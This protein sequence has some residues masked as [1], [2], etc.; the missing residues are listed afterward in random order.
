MVTLHHNSNTEMDSRINLVLQN[1]L[2]KIY[3]TV[4]VYTA[5][6]HIHFHSYICHFRTHYQNKS[7]VKTTQ[8]FR[9][10]IG[11]LRQTTRDLCCFLKNKHYLRTT[12]RIS[13][14]RTKCPFNCLFVKLT[15]DHIRAKPLCNFLNTEFSLHS[16]CSHTQ[17]EKTYYEAQYVDYVPLIST[18]LSSQALLTTY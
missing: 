18:S 6:K 14:H 2:N 4:Q 5:S 7:T 13:N 8:L 12:T 1:Q 3:L 11:S 15:S 16:M 10:L 17:G 9:R